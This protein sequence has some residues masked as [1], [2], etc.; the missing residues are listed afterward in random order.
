[1]LLPAD[2]P[3]RQQLTRLCAGTLKTH[4]AHDEECQQLGNAGTGAHA[5]M[6]LM[7]A[8]DQRASWEVIRHTDLTRV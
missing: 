2:H 3:G 6:Q 1:M 7:N 4:P 5:I 8:G